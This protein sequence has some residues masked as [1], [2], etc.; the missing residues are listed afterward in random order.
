MDEGGETLMT[1]IPAGD[2]ALELVQPSEQALDLPA[3]PIASQRSAV[4]GCR[5]SAV[6][7]MGRDQFNAFGREFLIERITV[8]GTIPNK[9]SGSSHGE[10][11]SE[12]RLDKG[13]FMWRSRSRVHGEWKTSSVCNNHELRTLAPLGLSNFEPP[14]FAT[15]KVPSM[16]HSERS[17]PPRSSRSR[18]SASNSFLSTPARTQREKRRKQVE[19]EGKRTGRSAQAAPVRSTQRMPFSTAR[20]ECI[21]GRPRPSWRRTCFGIRGSRI[22]HCSSVSCSALLMPQGYAQS[23]IVSPSSRYVS[24]HYL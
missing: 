19:P 11:F 21:S 20:S 7:A 4:L 16:K 18:A 6:A 1:A 24:Q 3:S 15:V 8:V 23:R 13:D 12:R 5:A 14:F 17:M 9:S 22:A 2:D 10:G